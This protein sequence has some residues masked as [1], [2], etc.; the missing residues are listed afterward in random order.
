[1]DLMGVMGM[2]AIMPPPPRLRIDDLR[3][4]ADAAIAGA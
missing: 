2:T 3:A 4:I 1:M